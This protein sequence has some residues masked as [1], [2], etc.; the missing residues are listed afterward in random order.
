MK[1]VFYFILLVSL[2]LQ[3]AFALKNNCDNVYAKITDVTVGATRGATFPIPQL[4]TGYIDLLKNPSS[5]TKATIREKLAVA[6]KDKYGTDV[7]DFIQESQKKSKTKSNEISEKFFKVLLKKFPLNAPE[8]LEAL[9]YIGLAKKAPRENRRAM[10]VVFSWV[11]IVLLGIDDS[12]KE[13]TLDEKLPNFEETKENESMV[14]LDLFEDNLRNMAMKS[15]LKEKYQAY[16]KNPKTKGK[17]IYLEIK[18]VWNVPAELL[19]IKK[20]YGPIA[21]FEVSAHGGAGRLSDS[22]KSF[23]LDELLG[24]RPL[25]VFASGAQVKF[26]SCSLA[27]G[28]TGKKAINDFYNTHLKKGDTLVASQLGVW[29]NDLPS[30]I[31]GAPGFNLIGA[32]IRYFEHGELGLTWRLSDPSDQVIVIRR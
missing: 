32:A 1:T 20:E 3:S 29:R 14:I 19:R 26:T 8:E 2:S 10:F 21:R 15:A 13:K 16:L 17:V 24:N 7:D 28:N 30:P 23:S 18:D 9:E 11:G 12:V 22:N 6:M 25:D 27:L 5:R 4:I 31:Q